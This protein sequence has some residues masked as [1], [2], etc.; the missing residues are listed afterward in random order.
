MTSVEPAE[1]RNF[2]RGIIWEAMVE[3]LNDWE[4]RVR[5]E[6]DVCLDLRTLGV[7]QGR[8]EALEYLRKMPEIKLQEAEE[9]ETDSSTFEDLADSG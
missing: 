7:I 5:E 9:L 4:K 6:Y 1:W 8:I 3:E 2:I